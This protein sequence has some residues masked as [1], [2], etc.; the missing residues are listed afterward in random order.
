M[1]IGE[2]SEDSLYAIHLFGEYY[3]ST[4]LSS[5][6]PADVGKS[7]CEDS[8]FL[9]IVPSELMVRLKRLYDWL[10]AYA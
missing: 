5:G 2:V 8:A 7:L 9:D 3:V 1:R 6:L 4:A 10:E